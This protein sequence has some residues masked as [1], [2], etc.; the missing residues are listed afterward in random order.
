MACWRVRRRS[1]HRELRSA[2]R[3]V[4]LRQHV[5]RPCPVIVASE[6]QRPGGRVSGR[7][8]TGGARARGR[9]SLVFVAILALVGVTA[10]TVRIVSAGAAAAPGTLPVRVVTTPETHRRRR[11]RSATAW[12]ATRPQVGG[13]CVELTVEA[14]AVGHRGQ[15]PDRVRRARHRHRRRPRAD[16]ERGH[17]ARRCGSPTRSR[18]STGSRWSTAPRSSRTCARSPPRRSWWRCRSR[19]PSQVGW[20]APLPVAGGQDHARPGRAQARA[21]PSRAGRRPAWPPPWCSARRWPRPTRTCRR[22]CRPSASVAKTA[23]H[24]RAAADPRA[25]RRPPGPAS[26]QA[27][28]AHNA[29]SPAVPLVAVRLDPAAAQLDYPYAIRSGHL[30]ADRAGGRAVP[31]RNCSAT[32]PPRRWPPRASAPRT[33]R[34]GPGSRPRP[35][36]TCRPSRARRSTTPAAVQRA[37]GLWSAANSPSRTLALFDVTASMGTPIGASGAT[38]ATVMVAA[39]QGGLKLFTGGQPG[40]HVGVRGPAPGGHADR[41][42]HPRAQGRDEP[43]DGRRPA[44]REQ[45]VGSST[46]TLQSPPTSSCATGTTRPGPT[47]SWC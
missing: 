25:P 35:P 4:R 46:R 37:L 30:P 18:G 5:P 38:R 19:P 23:E 2:Y 27:V 12:T 1:T 7:H 14:P 29:G 16:A 40:R 3:S 9:T 42:P 41:R 47:S 24:R 43:A 20:P 8:R 32:P 39:A 10:V 31:G 28:L 34:S 13:E 21:S 36:P 15:R 26:E 33:A 11:R 44:D 45:P 17:A 22:W 6:R